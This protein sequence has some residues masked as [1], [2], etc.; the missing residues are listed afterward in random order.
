MSQ[1]FSEGTLTFKFPDNWHICRPEDT[2]FYQ[3]HFQQFC[4]GSKEMDF[5]AFDPNDQVFWLIE[6]KDYRVHQRI[7][8]VELADEVATKTRDVLAMLPVG[9]LRD[10][11]ISQPGKLQ[12]R[13]FWQ[14][15]CEATNFRVVLHCELPISPSKLFPSI[16]DEANLQTKLS[17]KLHCIDPHSLFTN[18][19]IGHGLPWTVN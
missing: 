8:E 11:G 9:R 15:A 13:D 16:K 17:Q 4:N 2:S 12:I 7:K 6:V 1:D 19:S 18:R 14:Y 3:R 5:L 10:G